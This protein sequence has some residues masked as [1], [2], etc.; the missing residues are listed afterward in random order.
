MLPCAWRS[1]EPLG[2]SAFSILNHLQMSKW[3]RGLSTIWKI[4]IP[5]KCFMCIKKTSYCFSKNR[6]RYLFY[7]AEVFNTDSREPNDTKQKSHNILLPHVSTIFH[8]C[9]QFNHIHGPSQG[10][11]SEVHFL[12]VETQAWTFLFS[13]PKLQYK[14]TTTKDDEDKVYFLATIRCVHAW[15]LFWDVGVVVLGFC[16]KAFQKVNVDWDGIHLGSSHCVG[17]QNEPVGL[18]KGMTSS[19]EP[20]E[21]ST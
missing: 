5:R 11:R 9:P 13:L 15:L 8:H 4:S 1:N 17:M 6:M 10:F 21:R 12:H 19:W 16:W 20:A 2:W 18:C 14:G 3:L 7:Q